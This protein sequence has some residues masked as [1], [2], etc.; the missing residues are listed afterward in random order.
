M[1]LVLSGARGSGLQEVHPK[2]SASEIIPVL[3]VEPSG[4]EL[5][6]PVAQESHGWMPLELPTGLL[7]MPQ[8]HF[9]RG[10]GHGPKESSWE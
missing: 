5:S 4:T 1:Y 10:G 6:Y 3:L 2:G 7:L 9:L 8:L